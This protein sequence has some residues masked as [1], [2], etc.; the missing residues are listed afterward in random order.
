MRSGP[1]PDR[2][3]ACS[4]ARRHERAWPGSALLKMPEPTKTASAPRLTTQSSVGRRR[5]AARS[6]VRNRQLAVLVDVTNQV[7]RRAHVPGR[8]HQL[9]FGKRLDRAHLADHGAQVTHGL[10][11]VAAARLALGADHGGAFADAAKRFSQIAS[12]ANERST[13][14]VL[15]T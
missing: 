11:D 8:R 10:D 6:K 2:P 13:V 9:F 14:V 3:S 4:R 12:T 5:D 15:Q 1:L 7:V